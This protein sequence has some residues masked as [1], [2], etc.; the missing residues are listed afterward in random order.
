MA[1][2]LWDPIE[3]HSSRVGPSPDRA[4]IRISEE[5]EVRYWM[6]VLNVSEQQLRQAIEQVCHSYQ[7]V[8]K[9]LD[10]SIETSLGYSIPIE[11]S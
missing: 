10:R 3:T 5:P 1:D 4:V 9:H 11:I 7:A 6:K 8:R 2:D